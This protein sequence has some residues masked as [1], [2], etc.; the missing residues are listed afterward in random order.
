MKQGIIIKY[1][2]YDETTGNEIRGEVE[3]QITV[4]GVGI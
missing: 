3:V 4:D 1:N 2:K